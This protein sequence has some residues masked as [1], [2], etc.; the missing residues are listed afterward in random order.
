MRALA[1]RL[2]AC[3]ERSRWLISASYRLRWFFQSLLRENVR[4]LYN[5]VINT[6]VTQ[7]PFEA[8]I[9]SLF[10]SKPVLKI[11]IKTATITIQKPKE[12]TKTSRSA[13]NPAIGAT[14]L[15]NMLIQIR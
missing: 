4:M 12:A 1:Y 9:F 14:K 15:E 6:K 11:F 7:K 5:S 3:A 8:F 2:C 10:F 13:I